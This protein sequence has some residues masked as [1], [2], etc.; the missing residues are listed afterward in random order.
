[1]NLE[2]RFFKMFGAISI[3]MLVAISIAACGNS[4]LA[5]QINDGK[6]TICHATDIATNP[7]EEVTN[8]SSK[9]PQLSSAL[10]RNATQ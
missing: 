9:S 3:L 2:Q 10:L 8:S 5:A 4:A 6:I 7:Y 1:M